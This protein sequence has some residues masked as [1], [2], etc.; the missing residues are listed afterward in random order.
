MSQRETSRVPQA[1]S[2]P[3]GGR[4]DEGQRGE[5]ARWGR[6]PRPGDRCAGGEAPRTAAAT[7]GGGETRHRLS[8]CV[9]MKLA[10]WT[11][12]LGTLASRTAQCVVLCY[13]NP[14]RPSR[15]GSS[16]FG[17]KEATAGFRTHP[18]SAKYEA[19]D[20]MDSPS[21]Y[22]DRPFREPPTLQQTRFSSNTRTKSW[23]SKPVHRESASGKGLRR[24]AA[25]QALGRPRADRG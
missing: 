10:P 19:F 15:R 5:R 21:P 1:A 2:T 6:R 24:F 7:A 11:P 22:G 16:P 18:A 14:K 25:C 4:P 12:E 17:W 9:Q 8:L 13:G 3:D 23:E 20:L